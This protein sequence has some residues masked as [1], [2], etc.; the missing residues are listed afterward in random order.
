[1]GL[2][3]GLTYKFNGRHWGNVQ[4]ALIQR[5]PTLQN[6]FIN[7]RENNQLV[8][9]IQ[10]E[11]VSTAD[12]TYFLRLPALKGR[13]TG[14]Y[15]RFQ[16]TTDI[17]FFF[18][19]AG[20]GSDFV[21]EVI[22]DLDRLHMGLELGLEYQVSAAVKLSGVASVGKQLYASDPFVTINF[23]TA[24]EDG[25]FIDPKGN[26]DLGIAKI[27]DYRLAQGPQQAYALGVE[28]RDP[29]YWWVAVTT[30]YLARNYPNISTITR[31]QSFYLDP[32]TGNPFPEATPENVQK[33]LAQQQMENIYLLNLVGGK[34]WL[35]D[36]RYIS[37]F[38]SVNNLFDSVFRTGGYEQSRN[39]NY[40]QMAQ[41]QKSGTPSFATKYW[42]GYGRTYFLNLAIS[43]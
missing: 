23:D 41:D 19:D 7:P 29:K 12:A 6:S 13:V 25:E 37:I 1:M 17:N 10:T 27:K 39:G 30:N 9:N 42:Y 22:T 2:K 18:V 26:V 14:F 36:D 34:S 38:V 32:E 43:F 5:P 31:T 28:Y 3:G 35:V 15:S 16:N 8:P 33:L 4:A 20:I 21:Q 40:G 24:G 11:T